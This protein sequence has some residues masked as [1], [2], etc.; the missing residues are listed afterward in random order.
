MPLDKKVSNS[1]LIDCSQ[2]PS[3]PEGLALESHQS[4]PKVLWREELLVAYKPKPLGHH[5]S[6]MLQWASVESCLKHHRL[7]GWN[8]NMLDFVLAN[9]S[10][11]SEGVLARGS[12]LIFVG[13]SYS[14]RNFSTPQQKNVRRSRAVFRAVLRRADGALE[15]YIKARVSPWLKHRDLA[16][17]QPQ[18]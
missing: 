15:E 3:V 9:P 14:Q 16:A 12:A 11:V 8:A 1:L 2:P 13:T 6:V 17:V 7:I 5:P 4:S 18:G 10:Q